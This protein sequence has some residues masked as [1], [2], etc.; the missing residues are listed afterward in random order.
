MG[1]AR[2]DSGQHREANCLHLRDAKT[3]LPQDGLGI[4]LIRA[5]RRG[6]AAEAHCQSPGWL[7]G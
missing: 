2:P 3:P 7:N 1:L 5:A 4:T 6:L